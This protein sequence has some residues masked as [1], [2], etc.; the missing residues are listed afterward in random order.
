MRNRVALPLFLAV[1]FALYWNSF[2]GGFVFDDL[3]TFRKDRIRE[4]SFFDLADNYR[5]VRYLSL[6]IDETFFR[7][8]PVG[9][10]VVNTILHGITSSVVFVVLRRLAGPVAALAGALLFVAHP[11]HTECVAYISG[12]RDILTTLFFLLGFLAWLAFCRTSRWRWLAACGALYALAFFSKEMAVTLPVVCVLHDLLLDPAGAR[13]RLR[14]HVAMAMLAAVA[15]LR[16]SLSGVTRQEDWH[17]GSMTANYAMSARL[18]VHY[19]TL[20]VFPLRLLG[21]YSYEAYPLSRSFAEARALLSLAAVAAGVAAALFAR[22]R[23]PLVAFGTLW[24]LVTLLPVLQIVPFH[25]LAAEH[26]LYLPSVGFCLLAGLAFERLRAW[27]GPRVAWIPLGVVLALFAVRTVARNPD[28]RDSE[29]F[30]RRTLES[31][32]RCARAHFNVGMVHAQRA[33]WK[34]AAAWI[35]RAVAI[36]HD[37]VLARY[38]L[39]R[40]YGLLGRPDEMRVQFEK[41]L[42]FAKPMERPAVDPGALC[43]HLDRL[44]E[45]IAIYERRLAKGVYVKSALR[46]LLTCQ[47]R[48]GTEA[49]KAG[50]RDEALMRYRSAFRTAEQ[51][52]LLTPD[53]RRL[54]KDAADLALAVGD[55]ARA[56]ELRKRAESLPSAGR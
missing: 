45:A 5:P 16:V 18:V 24:F 40:I 34:E 43:I 49:G 10:H 56:D 47:T 3:T 25:E 12:R 2:H 46:G 55:R 42:R 6:R 38:Q 9:Y 29:T 27:A 7:D 48:L 26:Y 22:R 39:G 50:R 36:K 53:D 52:L 1:S 23:A 35:E 51:L 33:E 32:P 37:Y 30:W 44:D 13:R 41:T 17:G 28:W 31:A 19:A 21:D 11:V 4:R 8:N 20:L 14:M 54:L 15:A